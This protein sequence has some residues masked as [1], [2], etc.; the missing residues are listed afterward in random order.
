[1]SHMYV[2]NCIQ[3]FANQNSLLY[4][5]IYSVCILLSI[6]GTCV[7]LVCMI[8]NTHLTHAARLSPW[9]FLCMHMPTCLLT[10]FTHSSR[11]LICFVTC[12]CV[13]KH[14]TK[15]EPLKATCA[16]NLYTHKHN[17]QNDNKRRKRDAVNYW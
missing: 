5:Y 2:C 17:K 8:H 11:V 7:L 4:V 10:L 14:N 6:C 3:R 1:M 9:S 16:V 15:L 12:L 13:F